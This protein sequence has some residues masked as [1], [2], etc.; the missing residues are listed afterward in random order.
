MLTSNIPV[1]LKCEITVYIERAALSFRAILDCIT[2]MWR[3]IGFSK[4][5]KLKYNKIN[6]V[7]RGRAEA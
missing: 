7:V 4:T 1:Q 5:C 3:S 2:F 6:K